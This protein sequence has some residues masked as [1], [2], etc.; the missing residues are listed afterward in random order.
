VKNLSGNSSSATFAWRLNDNYFLKGDDGQGQTVF[1]DAVV[2]RLTGNQAVDWFF[3][4]LDA[5]ARDFITDLA[6]NESPTDI[7]S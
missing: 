3:A 5:C 1:D 4:N 2:D 7:D 6:A